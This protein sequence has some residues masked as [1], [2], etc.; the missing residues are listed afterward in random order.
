MANELRLIS[1]EPVLVIDL[2]N[3]YGTVS[4]YLGITGRYGLGHVLSHKHT[5]DKHL[6]ESVTYNYMEDFHVLLSPAAVE[7]GGAKSLQYE[8]LNAA[9]QACRETYKYIIVDAPRVAEIVAANL[10]AV[11]KFAL[12]VFQLTVKDLKFARAM[13]SSFNRSGISSKKIIPLAN[14]VKRMG[15]L[16]RLE[17]SKEVIGL[18]SLHRIRSDWRKAMKSINRG[19]PLAQVARRSGIR[20]DFIKLANKIYSSSKN[21]EMTGSGNKN[22]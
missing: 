1:S 5:I 15:P 13:T 9:L 18:D 2:D 12:I 6:I 8:N 3:C 4:D 17:D 10:A 22:V 16:V 21:G 11:S 20:R 19:Q 7:D 14:R